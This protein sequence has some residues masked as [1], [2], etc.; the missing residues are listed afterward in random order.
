M[1]VYCLLAASRLVWL[2]PLISIPITLS[3]PSTVRGLPR[4]LPRAQRAHRVQRHEPAPA[5]GRR[6]PRSLEDA[7][8]DQP[9][10]NNIHRCIEEA[11]FDL[12]INM[13]LD[14]NTRIR[15]PAPGT[16]IYCGFWIRFCILS[17]R[18]VDQFR[19]KQ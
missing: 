16:Y 6:C 13:L 19:T 2:Q 17:M 18:V 10:Q 11:M 9:L 15:S 14:S 8:S 12:K 7:A 4:L 3:S 5:A 1:L